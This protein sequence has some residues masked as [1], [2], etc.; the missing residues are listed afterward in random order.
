MALDKTTIMLLLLSAIL[1]INLYT[2][3]MTLETQAK[4]V[5]LRSSAVPRPKPTP[6]PIQTLKNIPA[7]KI[8]EAPVMTCTADAPTEKADVNA[9]KAD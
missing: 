2:L 3:K 9:I 7:P 4:G 1:A 5:P 8:V 6:V